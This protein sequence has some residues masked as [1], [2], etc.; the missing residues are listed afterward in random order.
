MSILFGY[1]YF[2]T[3]AEDLNILKQKLTTTEKGRQGN[4]AEIV[5]HTNDIK[6]LNDLG[7]NVVQYDFSQIP[8]YPPGFLQAP[9]I[10]DSDRNNAKFIGFSISDGVNT[11]TMSSIQGFYEGSMGTVVMF[12]RDQRSRIIQVSFTFMVLN[13][14]GN[15]HVQILGVDFKD[16][17]S[18]GNVTSRTRNTKINCFLLTT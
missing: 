11:P 3:I 4:A 1:D 14:S 16:I 9:D 18:S 8:R 7:K 13:N 5:T 15:L 17:D 6:R 2:D 10:S 12:T